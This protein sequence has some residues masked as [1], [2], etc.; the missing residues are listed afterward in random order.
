MAKKA[1][2]AKAVPAKKP[3]KR[4]KDTS[5]GTSDHLHFQSIIQANTGCTAKAAKETMPTHRFGL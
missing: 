1:T 5:E 2:K 3:V 4:H